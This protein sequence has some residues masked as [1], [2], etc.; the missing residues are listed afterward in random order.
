MNDGYST[1]F[2][3]LLAEWGHD[4]SCFSK[5]CRGC[6]LQTTGTLWPESFM[7]WPASATAS[8]GGLW[9]QPTLVPH[10]DGS[11]GGPLLGTPRT[12]TKNGASAVAIASGKH[13]HRLEAQVAIARLPTPTAHDSKD[14]PSPSRASRD[15]TDLGAIAFLLPDV[16]GS[17]HSE[18]TH[19][20]FSDGNKLWVDQPQNQ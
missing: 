10:I 5:T 9:Q 17:T 13:R 2:A 19:Q 15:T 6:C 4:P 1:T 11:D 18:P 20:Q 14:G 3:D 8:P 16:N 7:D 12:S